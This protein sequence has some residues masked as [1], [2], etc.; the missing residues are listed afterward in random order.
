[1][2]ATACIAMLALAGAA[3]GQAFNIDAGPDG[4]TVPSTGYGGASL[5]SGLWDSTSSAFARDT[6]GTTT[7]TLISFNRA[8]LVSQAI[9]GASGDDAVL[10][11]DMVYSGSSLGGA[12][13]V[14]VGPLA[15]GQYK[16][17]VYGWAGQVQWYSGISRNRTGLFRVRD[18]SSGTA[19]DFQLNY[20]DVWPGHQVLGETYFTF[21][22]NVTK[23]NAGFSVELMGQGGEFTPR[24]AVCNGIQI[25]PVPAPGTLA[26]LAIAPLLHRRRRPSSPITRTPSRT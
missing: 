7:S 4:Q 22:L 26:T 8:R 14:G 6:S 2:K 12:L 24:P 9:P 23:P 1:M 15:L 21:D 13:P 19:A 18:N 5:Q 20:T 17:Y 3:S 16:V 11:E 25:V 10:M